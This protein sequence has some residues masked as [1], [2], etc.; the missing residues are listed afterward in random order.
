PIARR[1]VHD[2][3]TYHIIFD[4]AAIDS[5]KK[6]KAVR[7]RLD[8]FVGETE[9]TVR[10]QTDTFG[11]PEFNEYYFFVNVDP[12]GGT[13]D[14]MEH[15]SSTRLV[16][17]GSLLKDDAYAD[18]V[19]VMSHEFFHIWNV[20][21]LRPAELGP[22]DYSRELYTTLLWFAEGF[23]QY[24]GHLMLR[25]A[26]VWDDKTL[27]SQLADEINAVDQSPG[28]F[29]RNL[30]ESS[31]DTWQQISARNPS[32]PANNLKNTYVNY[33]PKGAVAA[34]VLDL[35]IRRLTNDRRSLD[36]VMRE[37]Y[38]TH[39]QD[40]EVGAYYLRG[41]GYSQSDVYAAVDNVAGRAASI[42]LVRLVEERNEIDYA[43][44]LRHVGL[45]ITREPKSGAAKKSKTGKEAPRL[46]LGLVVADSKTRARSEFVPITNVLA[47]SPAERAGLSS[48]DL[49]I[50][51]DG[52][53]TDG[54][55]WEAVMELKRPGERLEITFFRGARMLTRTVTP[56]DVDRRPLRIDVA[57]NA[58]VKQRHSRE[59]WL[60]PR[61]KADK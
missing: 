7:D 23:T 27:Y 21:R 32:A 38:K 54:R 57:P 15:L 42:F 2:R 25:R 39:Y 4:I 13:F 53:R 60:G 34:F 5:W 28:R 29:H 50:A 6:S 49:I 58:T 52:E 9:K 59:R 46:F 26:G 12:Y 55:H 40:Q 20:K 51:V 35:E 45:M 47:D 44:Y 24:Y 1:F 17:D 16:Y 48:G 37:L 41:T 33:Y 22:F 18:L 11:R 36:D 19:G 8:R 56:E 61:I 3:I 14:G 10:T 43:R 31:Y 30:R